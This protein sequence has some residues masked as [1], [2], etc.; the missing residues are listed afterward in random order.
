MERGR[1]EAGARR[2]DVISVYAIATALFPVA[3]HPIM[4]CWLLV[5][6]N[7]LTSWTYLEQIHKFTHNSIYLAFWPAGLFYCLTTFIAQ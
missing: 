6:F 2:P 5:S 1:E 7:F 4:R 3:F